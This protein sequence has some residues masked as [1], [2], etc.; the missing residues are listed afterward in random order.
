M[1]TDLEQGRSTFHHFSL[2]Y[3]EKVWALNQA[4]SFDYML[5]LGKG[6]MGGH[7]ANLIARHFVSREPCHDSVLGWA[8]WVR[9]EPGSG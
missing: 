2:P 4:V 7:I 9:N 8:K 5:Y 1:S 6:W 3:S